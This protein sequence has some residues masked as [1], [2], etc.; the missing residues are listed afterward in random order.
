MAKKNQEKQPGYGKLLDAWVAPDDAGDPVGCL[1]TTF[2]FSPEFFEEEC[3]ARFLQLESD[4]TEDGP[5]YLIEREEKLAQIACAAA[6]VD[7]Y[8]C[9]G[10][11]SLRWDLLVARM[12]SGLL[13]AKVSLLYWAK[14]LRV[15]IAS[16]NLT[17][18][19]Y[20]RNQEV[21]GVLDYYDGG[22]APLSCLADVIA[23]MRSAAGFS[24]TAPGE[25]SPALSRWNALLAT[26][27]EKTRTWGL[28]DEELRRTGV[29][30]RAVFSGPG[31]P[32][33]FDALSSIWPGGSPPTIGCVYS[34]FFD[35]PELENRPARQLWATVRRR[36][37][38]TVEYYVDAENVPGDDA[39]FLSAPKSL[40]DAQ[41]TGRPEAS[42]NFYRV[43]T[44]NRPLHA[45]GVWLEDERW[46][47]YLIGSSN[48]T[49]AGTGL[50]KEPNFEAN[51]AYV[52]DTHRDPKARRLLENSFPRYELVDVETCQWKPRPEEEEDT[53]GEE[54]PLPQ[55]FGDATYH[56]DSQQRATV[57]LTLHGIPPQGWTLTADGIEDWSF[58]DV[59]WNEIGRPERVEAPWAPARPP[60][61]FWVRWTGS[62]GSAWWPVNVTAGNVL[63]P[64]DELKNLP[65]EVLIDILSSA[66]PLHRVLIDHER[67]KKRRKQSTECGAIVDPHKR[68]DTSQFLLQRTRRISTAL[69]ALRERVQKPAATIE[70]LRWRLRGPVGVLAF[71]DAL[72]REAQSEQERAFLLAE[73]ALEI[74]RAKPEG[75]NDCVPAKQHAQ[76]IRQILGEL[77]ALVPTD[78][79]QAP[80]NLRQYV[81]SAFNVV[82]E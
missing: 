69:N 79:L 5:V 65:L 32:T 38:A 13:H 58:G 26:V 35:R 68:V 30:V 74:R 37:E 14:L 57:A 56:S 28:S 44:D 52:I 72:V 15:I 20:R 33:V 50:S 29:H 27:A 39:L 73:L 9:R 66:R 45:K 75:S 18:D 8:H 1:A 64:P 60:S 23:F 2:T 62:I 55:Q 25:D 19:G 36:G 43:L 34:P 3:L 12:P 47:M 67:R 4:P 70:A 31:Y 63:P 76:E 46:S 51:L 54:V 71:A 61:G 6:L 17:E 22:E 78:T 49:S 24:R 11:R 7:K 80:D 41:P 59:N 16:A 21:F 77:R 10:S 82:L 48:F 53:L 42:T 81:Q 40:L